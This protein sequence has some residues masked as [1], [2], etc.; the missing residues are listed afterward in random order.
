MHSQSN[1]IYHYDGSFEGLLCCVFE[2]YA[3]KEIPLDILS[4][5][6]FQTTLLPVKEIPTELS[7]AERVR[8]S[9]PKKISYSALDFIKRAFLTCHTQKELYILL[10]L[11]K[12]YCC[13]ASVMSMLT[14]D[15]V[16]ALV[17][18]VKHLDK[19][20]HLLKGFIRFSVFNNALV[21]AIE[22][23]NYV[24]P[25]LARHFRER[26][27]EERFL[28][29]DKTHRMGLVYQP[30]KTVIIP[31]EELQLPEADE[32]EQAFRALWRLFYHTIEIKERHNPRCRMSLMPKRYWDNMTEFGEDN[33]V[34][35][36]NSQSEHKRKT[37]SGR[38][39][40]EKEK[41]NFFL[42]GREN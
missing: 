12:G 13:G 34:F 33:F 32:D 7:K 41:G 22:P 16:S 17:N 15:V 2:S 11:R 1:L 6:S 35:Q 8:V 24:L 25:F 27:P 3:Q 36:D 28:I 40:A 14:D 30:Y 5:A 26:Y 31:I 20:S 18:A 9:I 19:E 21:A 37:F 10:F 4:P 23:K 39:L 42:D 38:L 29:Y